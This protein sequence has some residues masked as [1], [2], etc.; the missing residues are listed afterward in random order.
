MSL[1][2]KGHTQ[3][4][5]YT[6]FVGGEGRGGHCKPFQVISLPVLRQESCCVCSKCSAPFT[7]CHWVVNEDSHRMFFFL[8]L[9]A[10]G[11]P[12]SP[13]AGAPGHR[14]ALPGFRCVDRGVL[15]WSASEGRRDMEL[16]LPSPGNDGKNKRLI[17][18]CGGIG[19]GGME[20]FLHLCVQT[21]LGGGGGSI[22]M[23]NNR[24]SFSASHAGFPSGAECSGNLFVLTCCRRPLDTW[25]FIL[26]PPPPTTPH[27][28]D[29]SNS[30]L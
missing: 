6:S 28:S 19:L 23:Q 7:R 15:R 1:G 25:I 12:V 26:V 29:C 20:A 4:F 5:Y 17:S 2:V 27:G 22:N 24:S 10:P 9:D 11:C 18:A 13:A 14:R 21:A 16:A 3:R 30:A 8:F